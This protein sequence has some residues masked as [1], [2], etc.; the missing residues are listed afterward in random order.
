MPDLHRTD[1]TPAHLALGGR[2]DSRLDVLCDRD[3][4]AITLNAGQWVHV[5]TTGRG[6]QGLSDLYLR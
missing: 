3:W 5:D 2:F 1:E 6:A 4:I